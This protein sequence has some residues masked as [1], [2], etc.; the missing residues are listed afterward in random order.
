MTPC[1]RQ[2]RLEADWLESSFRV[3]DL[4]V[5]VDNK[6]NI[7]KEVPCQ[8]T[9]PELVLPLYSAL[10]RPHLE[11]SDQPGAAQYKKDRDLLSSAGPQ[12]ELRDWSVFHM[13]GD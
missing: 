2:Y 5:L 8:K 4:G 6:L 1:M 10:M 12:R 11:R 7:P 9:L 13:R 3:K